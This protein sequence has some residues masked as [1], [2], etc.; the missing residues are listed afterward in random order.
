MTHPFSLT[1]YGGHGSAHIYLEVASGVT[2]FVL[3]GRFAERRARGRSGAALQALLGLAATHAC[4]LRDGRETRIPVEELAVGDRFVV[5]PGDTIATDGVVVEGASAVD[6]SMLTGEFVPA[7]VTEGDPVTGGCV[8]V[9]GRLVVEAA[10]V[11]GETRLAQIA[12]LV[13]QAQAGKAAVQRLADRVAGVFVPVVLVLAGLT[14]GFWVGIGVQ[15]ITATTAAT[16]VLIVACP[17]RSGW[18]PRPRCSSAPAVA[19]AWASSSRVRRSSSRRG[20]STP[21][22]STRPAP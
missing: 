3:A 21:S 7:E 2:T 13:E 8:N 4:V 5:R 18:R 15:P 14:F 10:R 17:A 20:R 11:G 1:V 22:C 19:P 6:S 16:A 12:A 9:G